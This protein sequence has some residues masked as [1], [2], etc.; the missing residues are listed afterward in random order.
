MRLR[1]DVESQK[2]ISTSPREKC[3]R[4]QAALEGSDSNF[5]RELH[6]H[7]SCKCQTEVTV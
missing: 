2:E 1:L 3:G 5:E 6:C 7:S 4:G